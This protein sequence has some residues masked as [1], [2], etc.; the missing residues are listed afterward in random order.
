MR[1]CVEPSSWLALVCLCLYH[2]FCADCSVLNWVQLERGFGY[3]FELQ[4]AELAAAHGGEEWL[5]F[6]RP[7]QAGQAG[8]SRRME[9]DLVLA[10]RLQA[11]E[12]EAA[13]CRFE[14]F[15]SAAGAEEQ[16]AT[17][18]VAMEEHAQR[19]AGDD[20]IDVCPD[21]HEMFTYYDETY[22]DGRLTQNA[23]VVEW[24]S[25][26]TTC[27]G[28]CSFRRSRGMM[29][30]CRIALSEPLLRY[31]G[32][33]DVKETLL[34]E[35]IHASVRLISCKN[36]REATWHAL[37]VCRIVA[38]SPALALSFTLW[39]SSRVPVT[40]WH[41]LAFGT[42]ILQEYLSN[43]EREGHGQHFQAK[44][45]SINAGICADRLTACMWCAAC[46]LLRA[47]ARG[48]GVDRQR[49]RPE[50]QTRQAHRQRSTAA[51]FK[52]C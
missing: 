3:A 51:H 19:E 8:A 18:K 2:A 1:E 4:K 29:G 32:A 21:V 34:H 14:A 28:T 41:F 17:N 10:R 35:M 38:I 49:D 12:D 36:T 20:S 30:M 6:G 39:L 9:I 26:M 47:S 52:T 25:R 24:S 7:D 42:S 44:M 23:V 46:I 13:F 31:R 11:E 50:R 16:G 48:G 22:F 27:A 33:T 40:P 37:D 5:P 45:R 15:A 43:R